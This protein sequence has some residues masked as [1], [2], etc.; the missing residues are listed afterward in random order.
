MWLSPEAIT[1]C[2]KKYGNKIDKMNSTHDL[3]TGMVDNKF[4]KDTQSF[5][6]SLFMLYSF[7]NG[8]L[9][10]SPN[11]EHIDYDYRVHSETILIELCKRGIYTING[12]EPSIVLRSTHNF[13]VLINNIIVDEFILLLKT[14]YSRGVNVCARQV[15]NGETTRQLVFA[16]DCKMLIYTDDFKGACNLPN[17]FH[18]L[19]HCEH[20]EYSE[21]FT[22][23]IDKDFT[24]SGL[25][26]NQGR[27]VNDKLQHHEIELEKNE[28]HSL[29]YV[30]TWCQTYDDCRVED[31]LLQLW[32]EFNSRYGHMNEG[33]CM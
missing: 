5:T 7:L 18:S 19:G 17:G 23:I 25:F 20:A 3:E 28:T 2:I 26:T 31:I 10:S 15:V 21:L 32:L 24:I 4:L 12:S 22:E 13:I 33:K 9:W 16:T 29:F 11:N 14:M 1:Q 8:S 27:T 6:E 30:E